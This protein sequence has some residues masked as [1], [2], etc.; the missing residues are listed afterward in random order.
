MSERFHVAVIG[1]GIIGCS[2]AFE[3][4]RRG[5]TVTVY[6]GRQVAA[7]A[8][9]ASAGILAPFTETHAGGPLVDLASRG[10]DAYPEFVQSVER[11]AGTRVDFERC[12]TIEVAETATR[13]SM[14]RHRFET[15]TGDE[16]FE[17][18]DADALR[19]AEPQINRALTGA[20]LCR[21]HGFVPVESFV[22]ALVRAAVSLGVGFRTGTRATALDFSADAVTVRDLHGAA[23]ATHVVLCAGAWS[24]DLDP[25]HELAGRLRP[26]RGQLVR[27]RS[28]EP[29]LRHVLWSDDC[30][31]VPW[32]SGEVLV[33]ATSEDVGFDERSTLDGV[34]S[35]LTAARELVPALGGAEF[36]SV[37]VGLRPATLDGVPILGPSQVDRR[38]FYATG[39]YRNGVLLAPL[40][41][42]LAANFIF[43]NRT[44]P[45]LTT[46]TKPGA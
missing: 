11:Q 42:Q 21:R 45:L 24:D 29:R 20:L 40:T 37:R 28:S 18:L 19:A 44:S 38:L 13:A 35:L 41:A 39:H 7:G 1:G 27:L 26:I 43:E 16:Q 30:Y 46:L 5:A 23:T 2:I 22:D 3:L 12:G 6:E 33:G 14:L 4:A 8:T 10:L 36:E 15:M 32:R 25:F 17:W 31:I 34:A 9:Q